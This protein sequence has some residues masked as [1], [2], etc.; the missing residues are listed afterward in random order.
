M[1]KSISISTRM[2]T[3]ENFSIFSRK[4]N[5]H[6]Q[7][8]H[9][10]LWCSRK[11]IEHWL[12]AAGY[13]L[14][15][16]HL[17]IVWHRN[18]SHK[19]TVNLINQNSPNASS[20]VARESKSHETKAEIKRFERANEKEKFREQRAR[21]VYIKLLTLSQPYFSRVSRPFNRLQPSV[22]IPVVEF[23]KLS[24][25]TVCADSS[26]WIHPEVKVEKDLPCGTTCCKWWL[27]NSHLQLH[28]I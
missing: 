11:S 25:S 27:D 8:F 9:R 26:Q 2:R 14:P 13:A 4:L 19:I 20:A 7:A 23:R 5:E 17:L 16:I 21:R 10:W 1:I 24:R 18:Y 22:S 3:T 12:K 6:F 15:Q 28:Q